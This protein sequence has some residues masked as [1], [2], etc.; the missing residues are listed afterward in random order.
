[1]NEQ[2]RQPTSQDMDTVRFISLVSMFASS[3]YMSMGKIANPSSGK[4]E[5]DLD[6]A[7]GF[8]DILV[9]LKTK[10]AGNL[11][12]D[13]DKI[14]T[15]TISD[16]QMNFVKEKEKP[17]PE[18]EPVPAGEEKAGEEELPAAEEKPEEPAGEEKEEKK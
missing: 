2:D 6:A 3:A 15:S 12:K 1:M 5:R 7:R 9:M 16:L 4:A 14:I 18:P 8:I 10:T 17:E 11:T 13:E